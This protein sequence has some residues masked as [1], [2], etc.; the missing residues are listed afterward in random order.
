[1][2]EKNHDPTAGSGEGIPGIP[3]PTKALH[4]WVVLT[5]APETKK[6]NLGG[7]FKGEVGNLVLRGVQDFGNVN[8]S[9]L[10]QNI[11]E[12]RYENNFW[13]LRV[14]PATWFSDAQ[15]CLAEISCGCKRWCKWYNFWRVR[16]TIDN[17]SMKSYV[18]LSRCLSDVGSK[19]MYLLVNSREAAYWD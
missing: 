17:E 6:H 16:E 11:L 1:M 12:L 15:N 3:A 9:R 4:F 8:M 18:F 10:R 19:N 13:Y 5:L 2:W 7:G 14:P